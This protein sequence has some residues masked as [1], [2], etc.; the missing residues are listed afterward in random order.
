MDIIGRGHVFIWVTRD[1]KE[2]SGEK[3]LPNCPLTQLN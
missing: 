1:L 3:W 2:K